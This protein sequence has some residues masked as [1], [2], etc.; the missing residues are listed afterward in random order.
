MFHFAL[1]AVYKHGKFS[2]VLL[3][4]G[5]QFVPN[6]KD[7]IGAFHSSFVLLPVEINFFLK[8]QGCKKDALVA[9]GTGHI[10]IILALSTKVITF[11]LQ[12]FIIQVK[13]FD[14]EG[15]FQSA[16]FA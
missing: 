13:V 16:K 11:Y 9:C 8:E 15:L 6:R 10:K 3:K 1:D 2:E 5:L 12:T 4:K 14:L 7:G